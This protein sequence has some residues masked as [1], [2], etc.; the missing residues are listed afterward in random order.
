[1]IDERHG[2]DMTH[3][4]FVRHALP[5]HRWEIDR[6]R[7]LT[8]EG[9]G[10]TQ[11][12]SETLRDIK[13]DYAI[14]SPYIRSMDTIKECVMEHGLVMDLDE[15]FRERERGI[16]NNAKMLSRRWEDFEFHEEQ[17]ESLGMVQRRNIEALKEVLSAHAGEN[18]LIGTHA[19]ALSTI[20]NYYDP[21]YNCESF[22]RIINCMPFMIRLDFD[23]QECVGKEELLIV[24]KD[25]TEYNKAYKSVSTLN[26]K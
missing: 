22:M 11:K 17:G 19:T 16:H 20:L 24:D 10:D 1:M 3:I 14:S 4:Y 6:T 5:E 8:D 23:G 26:H 12:V 2:N 7:P 18:I 13:L 21:T 25:V 15:R 9:R